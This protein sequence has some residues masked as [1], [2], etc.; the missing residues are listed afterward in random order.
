MKVK[1]ENPYMPYVK[2]IPI[3][4]IIDF[5]DAKLLI[6]HLP[7]DQLD[8]IIKFI[9]KKS[10]KRP[11]AYTF[12]EIETLARTYMNLLGYNKK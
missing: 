9:S 4:E 3:D 2:N 11:T 10:R 5:L 6:K 1:I 8:N 12:S 7:S